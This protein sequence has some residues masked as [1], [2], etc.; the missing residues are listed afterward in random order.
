MEPKGETLTMYGAPSESAPLEW[1]WVAGE[2]AAAGTYWIA[3]GA[4]RPHARPVWGVWGDRLLHLSIGSPTVRRAIEQQPLVTIHLGSAS[5]VVLMEGAVAG[6]TDDPGIVSQYE[7][8]Y[9]WTYDVSEYGPLTTIAV[10]V[11]MAWRSAGW[12]GRDG[13]VA[14]GRWRFP[15][16][17]AASVSS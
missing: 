17:T 1:D 9:D 10:D 3:A 7:R 13:F 15:P 6:T 8:K 16:H 5:D 12:A 2:L 4:G 14:T 11:V